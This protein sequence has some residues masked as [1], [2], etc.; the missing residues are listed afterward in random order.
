[1]KRWIRPFVTREHL[2]RDTIAALLIAAGFSA[3]IYLA[4]CGYSFALFNTVAGLAAVWGLLVSPRRTVVLSGFFIGLFWF[5]WVGFSFRYYGLTWMVPFVSLG[6]GLGYAVIFGTMALTRNPLLRAA[7]LFGIGFFEPFDFNWM[8]PALLFVQ[9]W[10]GTETWQFA[11][12]LA[13][14]GLFAWLRRPWRYG[15]FLLLLGALDLSP[16]EPR[17]LPPLSIKLVP[18]QL[19]Q[20]EKWVPA[21]RERIVD[22]NFAAIDAAI[23]EGYDLVVLHESAFPLFLNMRPDLVEQL[24]MRSRQ[25]AIV[26]GALLYENG[27]NFN[28]TYLFEKGRMQI[29]KKMVLV[30]FGEYIPLPKFLHRIVNETFFDGASD[31][32]GADAPSTLRIGGIAFRNAICYEATCP[33]LF[34]DDPQYMIAISNNAWFLPSTEPTLQHLLMEYFARQHGTVIFHAANMA[35]TGVIR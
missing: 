17:P 4:H 29:A 10:L 16:A 1:M 5:Y 27:Q 24:K 13:A 3:F 19:L 30:P 22:T 31:Y 20:E 2:G 12:T 23:S 7:V 33:E 14:V 35:G 8:Q 26:T 32:V 34:A 11:L 18:A 6:F 9:S 28:V 25:I 15:A 21:N